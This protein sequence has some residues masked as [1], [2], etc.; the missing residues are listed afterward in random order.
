M[1]TTTEKRKCEGC[2]KVFRPKRSNQRFHCVR[3]RKPH[4]KAI[5]RDYCKLWREANPEKM[6]AAK[7]RF[8]KSAKGKKWQRRWRR[9]WRRERPDLHRA[10]V[11]RSLPAQLLYRKKTLGRVCR[12]CKGTDADRH[13]SGRRDLCSACSGRGRRNGFTRDGRAKYKPVACPG[14]EK[15]RRVLLLLWELST[16]TWPE[17]AVAGRGLI[18]LTAEQVKEF[19]E[20]VSVKTIAHPHWFARVRLLSGRFD[21]RVKVRQDK[22]AGGKTWRLVL[23]VDRVRVAC[24]R[25]LDRQAR[26][27]GEPQDE[28]AA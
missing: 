9:K 18:A 5:K 11:K 13:W 6:K 24:A 23:E 22:Q 28:D 10:Q 20:S 3:C 19:D 25:V 16:H 12:S 8:A 17:E 7:S 14:G 2:E 26:V 15:S 27:D 21:M 1:V 4:D